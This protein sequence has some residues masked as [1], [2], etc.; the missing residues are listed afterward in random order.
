MRCARRLFQRFQ[1]GVGRLRIEPVSIVND[2]DA[3]ATFIGAKVCLLL[4]LA[5]RP[6][7]EETIKGA[8][9]RNVR[10]IAPDQM[11][12]SI[13]LLSIVC[14]FRMRNSQTRRA[15]VASLNTLWRLTV[16]SFCQFKRKEFFADALFA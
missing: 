5:H 6:D 2:K 4:D 16:Q 11:L 14:K 8:R 15:M 9:E 12:S 1:E 7:S 10:M 13:F 3:R